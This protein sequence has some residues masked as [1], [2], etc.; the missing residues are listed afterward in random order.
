[1]RGGHGCGI[2]GTPARALVELEALTREGNGEERTMRE[3]K[4]EC[5]ADAKENMK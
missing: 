5:N 3:R 2:R 4:A 1:M